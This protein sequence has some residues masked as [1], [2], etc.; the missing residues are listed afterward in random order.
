MNTTL[1]KTTSFDT[2]Y[3]AKGAKLVEEFEGMRIYEL[4][5]TYKTMCEARQKSMGNGGIL[6]IVFDVPQQG[7]PVQTAEE[8]AAIGHNH[9]FTR[10]Y[11]GNSPSAIQVRLSLQGNSLAGLNASDIER[12]VPGTPTED[13]AKRQ[14][15]PG[16][17]VAVQTNSN[18][19]LEKSTM[20]A[21]ADI[22]KKAYR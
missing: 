18:G 19:D 20:M 7:F 17:T 12:Y 1:E 3:K 21:L 4:A 8:I 14:I 11:Y 22:L 6:A 16:E 10:T 13:R 5:P 15:M 2:E 9:E